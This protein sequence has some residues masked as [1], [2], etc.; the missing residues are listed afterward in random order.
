MFYEKIDKK[1]LADYLRK[2]YKKIDFDLW[3]EVIPS[4]V[5]YEPY[6]PVSFED[7]EQHAEIFR[8]NDQLLA[9]K[10]AQY[11]Q[12]HAKMIEIVEFIMDVNKRHKM[13]VLFDGKTYVGTTFEEYPGSSFVFALALQ[14]KKYLELYADFLLSIEVKYSVS[15]RDNS[16]IPIDHSFKYFGYDIITQIKKWNW[17]AE[18]YYLL[19]AYWFF[20]KEKDAVLEYVSRTGFP[21]DLKEEADYWHFVE[22]LKQILKKTD[23]SEED[24]RG[25][26]FDLFKELTAYI[27]LDN[28][29]TAESLNIC[30][31]NIVEGRMSVEQPAAMEDM[32]DE[33]VI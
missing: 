26:Y 11:P 28:K 1:R 19:L 6:L 18:T 7:A 27:I 16:K 24:K 25:K 12:L 13:W 5:G 29:K 22:A 17:C 15:K 9:Y 2:L 14:D 3:Y 20:D 8:N 31:R 10:S 4:V 33:I 32:I 23:F 21:V 30:Y